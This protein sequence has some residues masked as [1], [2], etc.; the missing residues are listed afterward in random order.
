M[1]PILEADSIVSPVPVEV[2]EYRYSRARVVFIEGED[3]AGMAEVSRLFYDAITTE[4]TWIVPPGVGH[5]VSADP[6]GAEAVLGELR[7]G[8]SG[9]GTN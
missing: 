5:A 7:E 1:I 8:V 3:D 9:A 4:K 2:R 6:T